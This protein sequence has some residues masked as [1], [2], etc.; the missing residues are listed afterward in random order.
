MI[1][2]AALVMEVVAVPEAEALVAGPVAAVEAMAAEQAGVVAVVGPVATAAELSCLTAMASAVVATAAE[3]E[4]RMVPVAMG[5]RK[6]LV[7]AAWAS[8]ALELAKARACSMAERPVVAAEVPLP[9]ERRQC[10]LPLASPASAGPKCRQPS[11][12]ASRPANETWNLAA[13]AV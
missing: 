8:E 9:W 11:H 1:A 7:P 5:A 12:R 2:T 10:R 3:R 6:S 13:P 4:A